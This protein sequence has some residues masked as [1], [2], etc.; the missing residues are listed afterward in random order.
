MVGLSFLR[1]SDLFEGLCDE[2]LAAISKIAHEEVYAAG[3]CILSEHNPAKNLYIVV[4]GRVAILIN[5][6]RGRQTIISTLCQNSSFG[7]S[8]MVPPFMLTGTAK[9]M[10]D[11]RT[12]VIPADEL[13]SFCRQSCTT[14]YAIMEKV[15]AMVSAE[16]RDARL[17]LISRM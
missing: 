5:I 1:K 14:C 10:E 8:A 2:E 15:A 13:R 3:A 17:Q 16:L 11:T 7:W 4:E 9:A 12:I 6:G